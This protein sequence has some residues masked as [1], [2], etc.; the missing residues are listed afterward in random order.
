MVPALAFCGIN[1]RRHAGYC[2]GVAY[3]VLLNGLHWCCRFG[4]GSLVLE[5]QNLMAPS[6]A[7]GGIRSAPNL[8]IPGVSIGLARKDRRSTGEAGHRHR[9][10]CLPTTSHSQKQDPLRSAHGGS[11]DRWPPAEGKCEDRCDCSRRSAS[12]RR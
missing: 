8:A 11:R 4:Y 3:A 5:T 9:P 6:L 12:L 1:V 2:F 7:V 10:R